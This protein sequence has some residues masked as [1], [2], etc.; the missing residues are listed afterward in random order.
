MV[1]S[2]FIGIGSCMVKEVQKCKLSIKGHLEATAPT[3]A[4]ICNEWVE[5]VSLRWGKVDKATRMSVSCDVS[6]VL[7]KKRVADPS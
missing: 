2:R 5:W 7:L 1:S 3:K 4:A 6:K